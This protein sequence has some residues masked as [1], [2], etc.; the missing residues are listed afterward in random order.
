MLAWH[1][2]TTALTDKPPTSCRLHSVE[3]AR[4]WQHVQTRSWWATLDMHLPHQR[5]RDR[6][7]SSYESGRAGVEAWAA[8]HADRLTAEVAAIDVGRPCR[9]WLPAGQQ[10]QPR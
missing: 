6:E 2:L 7:C 3:I 5:R 8:R 4:L 10:D 1:H 9:S